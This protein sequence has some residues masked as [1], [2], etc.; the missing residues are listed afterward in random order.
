MPRERINQGQLPPQVPDF[1]HDMRIAEEVLRHDSL[2][3][4]RRRLNWVSIPAG[5]GSW[6]VPAALIL[7][8]HVP[9]VA[10]GIASVYGASKLVKFG[11]KRAEN[12]AKKIAVREAKKTNENPSPLAAYVRRWKKKEK[13][14][15]VATLAATPLAVALAGEHA[16]LAAAH[17]AS[18]ATAHAVREA[19]RHVATHAA[20]HGAVHVA[21]HHLL[22]GILGGGV[23]Q[24]AFSFT[25][26]RMFTSWN[27]KRMAR[28]NA[29]QLSRLVL[30][31]MSD[32]ELLSLTSRSQK[33]LRRSR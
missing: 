16:H 7:A 32:A 8:G 22:G 25:V 21:K 12:H 14:V 4:T 28:D 3:K 15:Q 11:L 30:G 5:L 18:I 31:K 24:L 23:V 29:I 10:L 1:S 33:S 17:G 13:N 27:Q 6:S 2:R 20:M 19:G 26:G 9:P